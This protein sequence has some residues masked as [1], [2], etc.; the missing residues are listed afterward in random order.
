MEV[1]TAELV[2]KYWSQ[3]PWRGDLEAYVADNPYRAVIDTTHAAE[4]L[5]WRA[6]RS[7]RNQAK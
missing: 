6:L 3:L 2:Q 1:P 4:V 5:G 7:W